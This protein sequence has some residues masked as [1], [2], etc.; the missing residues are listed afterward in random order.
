MKEIRNNPEFKAELNAVVDIEPYS[1]ELLTLTLHKVKNYSLY[2]KSFFDKSFKKSKDIL[3]FKQYVKSFSRLDNELI[4]T[5][6]GEK[7]TFQLGEVTNKDGKVVLWL[8]TDRQLSHK[9]KKA[10]IKLKALVP[11]AENVKAYGPVNYTEK[12]PFTF[13]SYYAL[14]KETPIANGPKAI[15]N[16]GAIF[17]YL[18]TQTIINKILGFSYIL[19]NT[20]A[21]S[22]IPDSQGFVSLNGAVF[23]YGWFNL[24]AP[25][26]TEYVDWYVYQ[27]P[28]NNYLYLYSVKKAEFFTKTNFPK[29]KR[30]AIA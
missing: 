27:Q 8:I 23:Y 15:I 5:I 6:D 3:T 28:L 16:K 24:D 2:K 20:P 25:N 10:G 13:P 12:N 30:V 14:P 22:F 21:A 26:K 17:W 4:I 7:Y 19:C 18:P 29:T 9:S 1:D 11:V